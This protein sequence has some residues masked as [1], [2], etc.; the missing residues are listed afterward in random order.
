M[1]T[2]NY[3][4]GKETYRK[5]RKHNKQNSSHGLMILLLSKRKEQDLSIL[6]LIKPHTN[7]PNDIIKTKG[8]ICKD[9]PFVYDL[10]REITFSFSYPFSLSCLSYRLS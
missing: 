10:E 2:I 7:T 6:N 4:L 1:L 8:A 9:D 5:Q 3:I